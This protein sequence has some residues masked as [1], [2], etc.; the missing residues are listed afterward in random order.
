MKWSVRKT[1]TTLIRNAWKTGGKALC[2]MM[3]AVAFLSCQPSQGAAS[4]AGI[5]QSTTISAASPEENGG[6]IVQSG[7]HKKLYGTWI[8][9]DVDTE[10]G[11][12][13]IKLTF[14]RV[15]TLRL[16]AWSDIPFAGKVR[17]LKAPYEVHRDTIPMVASVRGAR[18]CTMATAGKNLK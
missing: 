5:S 11:E 18:L 9:H 16:L 6:N 10:M 14:R 2:A 4:G 13:K 7:P 15:G 3:M 17:D 8:A 1:I 12:V